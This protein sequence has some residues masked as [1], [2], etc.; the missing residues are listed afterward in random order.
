MSRRAL[1][2][3]LESG[4]VARV[5]PDL[6]AAA[7]ELAVGRRHITT[8]ASVAGTDPTA[9]FAVGYEAVRKA[10]SAHMR[11]NGYRARKG[12]GHHARIGRYALA[13]LDAPAVAGHLD[14]FDA[15][16]LL[17]NQSQY[18]GLEIEP[19]EVD[20]LLVHARAIVGAIGD[21]LSL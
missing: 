6:P 1:A 18:E 21:D 5:E 4:Q 2:E 14:A 9:A 13:A 17:R 10:I 15:L 19:A 12:Q 16:R 3:L 8:A 20:E 7:E 11:A